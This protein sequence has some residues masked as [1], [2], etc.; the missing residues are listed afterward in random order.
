MQICLKIILKCDSQIVLYKLLFFDIIKFKMSDI[1]FFTDGACSNN[2]SDCERCGSGLCVSYPDGKFEMYYKSIVKGDNLRFKINSEYKELIIDTCTNNVAELFAI[3]LA[4]RQAKKMNIL[5][6]TIVSDS[7]YV[8]G[9]FNSNHRVKKNKDL[10]DL[11]KYLIERYNFKINW[12]H[13]NSHQTISPGMSDEEK[14]LII[15]NQHA[16]RC[17]VKGA[18]R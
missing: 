5:N 17:A 11:I 12:K 6:P 18:S 3:I 16:D 1:Y 13:V 10:I 7:M 8:I 9:I 14:R 2:R 15:G 4:L